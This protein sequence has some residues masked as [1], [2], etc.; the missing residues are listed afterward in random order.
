[1]TRTALSA[2]LAT[3]LLAGCSPHG[4]GP[5]AAGERGPNPFAPGA[6]RQMGAVSGLRLKAPTVEAENFRQVDKNLYRCGV[7]SD[8]DMAAFARLGIKTD[9]SLQFTGGSEAPVVKHESAVAKQLGI[10]FVNI[11]LPFGKEPPAAMVKKYFDIFADEANLPAIVHCKR[12]RDRTG[13]M[14]AIYRI[15]ENG[16]SNE[17]AFAEQESFG[18]KKKDYPHYANYVLNFGKPADARKKKQ[19]EDELAALLP[20]FGGWEE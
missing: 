2:L 20:A 9:I 5:G 16:W 4:W 15:Q 12:G 17:K 10:K 13:T 8:E 18:F 11:P 1:M 6:A 3:I 14:V 19:R 7:P